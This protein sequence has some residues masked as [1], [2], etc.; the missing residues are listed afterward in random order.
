MSID[1]WVKAGSELRHRE[2]DRKP[3]VSHLDRPNRLC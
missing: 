3:L 1:V 2:A